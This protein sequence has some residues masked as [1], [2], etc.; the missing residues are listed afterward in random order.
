MGTEATTLLERT[1]N[2]A[3]H[4][5]RHPQPLGAVVPMQEVTIKQYVNYIAR[6]S[7]PEAMTIEEIIGADKQERTMQ[8]ALEL[9][10]S[11]TI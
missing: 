5:S 7:L 4:M 8:I 6:T 11:G 3:E 10:R 9:T 1:N 2:P